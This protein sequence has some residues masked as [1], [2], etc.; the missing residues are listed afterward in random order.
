MSVRR[1]LVLILG[2]V[3]QLPEGDTVAI[4]SIE[5]LRELLAGK[6][7]VEDGMAAFAA[8]LA[9][10]GIVDPLE[11]EDRPAGGITMAEAYVN[12]YPEWY[13]NVLRL[14]GAD[15]PGGGELFM[16]WG[17]S[18]GGVHYRSL[19]DVGFGWGAWRRLAFADELTPEHG[20]VGSYALMSLTATAPAATY[21]PGDELDATYLRYSSAGGT[22]D[23]AGASGTWRCMGFATRAGTNGANATLW[24]RIA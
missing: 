7:D 15:I 12:G 8:R 23:V 16:G 19:A 22:G 14:I 24:L 2:N 17:E 10:F 21:N 6:L 1:P 9:S 11:G 18:V 5:G 3:K 13:G 20:E 4:D